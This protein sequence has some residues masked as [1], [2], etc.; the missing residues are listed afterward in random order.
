MGRRVFIVWTNPLFL[1]SVRLLLNHP[2]IEFVGNTSSIQDGMQQIYHLQP[3][4]IVVEELDEGP[5]TEIISLLEGGRNPTRI[6]GFSMNSNRL[7]LYHREERYAD[8]SSD[9]LQAIISDL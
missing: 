3:D 2:E 7:A 1:E 6:I 9:L 5:P 8:Q 4:T